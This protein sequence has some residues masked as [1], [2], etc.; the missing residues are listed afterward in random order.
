MDT[1]DD[2]L[3]QIEDFEH[4]ARFAE[5]MAWM[6]SNYPKLGQ[7]IAWN[8]PMYID[9]G[10][11]IISF[12]AYKHHMTVAPEVAGIKHFEEEIAKAGYKHTTMLIQIPWD[13]PVNYELMSKLI[14][15]NIQDKADVQTFWRK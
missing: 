14:D 7:R 9:H 12:N 4:R 2:Y 11:F 3:D 13:K 10:T 5:V 6:N 1:F 8:Q 15:F